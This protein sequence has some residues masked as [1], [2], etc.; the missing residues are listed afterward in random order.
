[1]NY[2]VRTGMYYI[3]APQDG[4]ITKA[5][6]SGLGETIKEG[7]Q[8]V[9]I[10]PSKYTLAVEMYIKPIDLPLVTLGQHVRLQF[11][12]WP[13]IVFSGWP[14]TS[15]GTYGGEVVAIDNFISGN[16][17]YRILVAPDPDDVD[18]PDALR[19]GSGASSM[20][21]LN[22]VPIWYELWRKVNGFPPNYYKSTL[23]ENETQEG[24]KS[25][26]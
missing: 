6:Q 8:I 12:G 16:G 22:D 19:V 3:T 2:S 26:K 11:D 4:Y 14:N 5:I 20:I 15:Y 17:K 13:A 23:T 10:M 18:W 21:L 24:G 1:M 7:E 9:S 25:E